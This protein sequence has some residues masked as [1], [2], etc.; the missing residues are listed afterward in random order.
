MWMTREK[1]LS[2]TSHKW[3]VEIIWQSFKASIIKKESKSSDK[4]SSNKIEKLTKIIKVIK[5]TT[6]K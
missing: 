3:D 1:Q 6:W 2:P 5:I 4:L